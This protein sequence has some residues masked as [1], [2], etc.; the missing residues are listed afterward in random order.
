[1]RSNLDADPGRCHRHWCRT[2]NP[3][4][5]GE[6]PIDWEASVDENLELLGVLC[7]N[8]RT[9]APWFGDGF[10]PPNFLDASAAAS[11]TCSATQPNRRLTHTGL[12]QEDSELGDNRLVSRCLVISAAILAVGCGSAM[13]A[14]ARDTA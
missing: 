10:L 7:S 14:A 2:R 4:P 5:D 11:W 6:L 1:M 8:C 3:T 9:V 13:V 12:A